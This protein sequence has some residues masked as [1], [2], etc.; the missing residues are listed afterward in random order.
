MS[1]GRHKRKPVSPRAIRRAKRRAATEE[2]EKTER[3]WKGRARQAYELVGYGS[4][5]NTQ[6]ARVVRP[7]RGKR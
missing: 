1:K 4:P 7:S 2:L 5:V 3:F 6:S